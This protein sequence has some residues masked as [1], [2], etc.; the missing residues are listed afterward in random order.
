MSHSQIIYR[1]CKSVLLLVSGAMLLC[2]VSF[3]Q[4]TS[5][6]TITAIATEAHCLKDGTVAI[7]VKK[8]PGAVHNIQRITYNLYDA[9]GNIIL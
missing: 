8:K 3:A 1:L 6:V 5:D 2:G 7:D 4:T 9:K